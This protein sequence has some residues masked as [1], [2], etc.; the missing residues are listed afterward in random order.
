MKQSNT[1]STRNLVLIAMLSA[2]CAVLMVFQ[3]PVPFALP[4]YKVDISDVPALI[5]AFAIS[6]LAGIIIELLKNVLHLL[7]QGST[8]FTVGEF[9]NF[10][11]GALL[12]FPAAVIYHRHKTKKSA[13]IGLVVASLIMSVASCFIN[14]YITLPFY[15]KASTDYTMDGIVAWAGS[16]NGFVKNLYT[17][18][19]FL[20]LPFNIIK[21]GLSSVI[22]V[23]LYKRV[24]P[25]LHKTTS[26]SRQEILNAKKDIAK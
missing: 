11:S 19:V 7:L 22:T 23:L 18:L 15:I 12:V 24:A 21:C 2:L 25:L 13:I 9:A 8:T 6:P 3:F 4:F 26:H 1:F 10:L 5:G 16:V 17:Y 20:V 14:A